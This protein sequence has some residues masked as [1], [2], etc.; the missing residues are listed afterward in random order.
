MNGVEDPVCINMFVRLTC[1][2]GFII[3]KKL[4]TERICGFIFQRFE[5][6][7]YIV[8]FIVVLVY[9]IHT[10]EVNVSTAIVVRKNSKQIII[11][12]IVFD[13]EI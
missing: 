9:F 8:N 11:A 12:K 1:Q 4:K 7:F 6:I 5:M 3:S 2:C 13:R 10:V